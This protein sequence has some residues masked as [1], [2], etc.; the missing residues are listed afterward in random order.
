MNYLKRTISAFNILYVYIFF[1]FILLQLIK[2]PFFTIYPSIN[3][4]NLYIKDFIRMS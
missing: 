4:N 3:N 2:I 1:K